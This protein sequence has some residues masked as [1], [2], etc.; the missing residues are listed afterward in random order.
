[1]ETGNKMVIDRNLI[2]WSFEEWALISSGC[3]VSVGKTKKLRMDGW[4]DGANDYIT[5]LLSYDV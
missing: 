3:T 1:M 2:T 4:M 5:V